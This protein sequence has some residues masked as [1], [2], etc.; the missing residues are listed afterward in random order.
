VKPDEPRV[1]GVVK[2]G[3]D[4]RRVELGVPGQDALLPG[5]LVQVAVVEHAD[6]ELLVLPAVAEG[7]EVDQRVLPSICIAPSRSRRSRA[8]RDKGHCRAGR[9]RGLA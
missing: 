3:Q 6:D 4:L 7:G 8:G 9:P 2:V 1:A 5:H